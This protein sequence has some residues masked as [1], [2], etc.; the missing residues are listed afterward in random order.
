VTGRPG[1]R[2]DPDFETVP[3]PEW[4]ET[5]AIRGAEAAWDFY[6]ETDE[7]WDAGSYELVELID[8]GNDRIVAHQRRDMRGRASGASVVYDY[9][10]VVTFRGEKAV[11]AEWFT[12]RP[13]ALDAAAHPPPRQPR[14]T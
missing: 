2:C 13:E 8:A 5:E 7:P 11:R 9:W 10:L 4:P 6:V 12:N 14:T 1:S 3:S